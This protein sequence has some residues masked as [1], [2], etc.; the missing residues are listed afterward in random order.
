M[1]TTIPFKERITCTVPEAVT[2]SGIGRTSLYQA[3]REGRLQSLTYRKRRLILVRSL[4]ELLDP[5][6][7]SPSAP[8][9]A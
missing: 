8:K 4:L 2:A 1:T 9:A 7:R 6:D 3:I 5:P